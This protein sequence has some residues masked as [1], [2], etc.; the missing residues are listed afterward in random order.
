MEP[1]DY[2][3]VPPAGFHALTRLYDLACALVGLGPRFKD[4]IVDL[5][6]VRADHRVLD[7]GAGTGTLAL[8][9]LRRVPGLALELADPDA[10]SLALARRKAERAGLT[11]ST[12]L[13]RAED[14]PF[15]DAAFDRVFCTLTLHHVPDV[16]KGAALAEMR[17]VLRPGGW[18]LL[19]DFETTRHHWLFG[20]RARS[21]KPL[22]EWLEQAGLRPE[23][24]GRK[25]FVDAW[26]GTAA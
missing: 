2:S 5:G 12:H 26:R 8:Q 13:A 24:L 1:A 9:L 20:G 3:H 19:A 23:K 17:R 10:R 18:L 21:A 4:W 25:R 7:V 16:A 11:L 15:G 14:L 6:E 22:H